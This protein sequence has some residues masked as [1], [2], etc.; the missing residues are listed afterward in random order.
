[1]IWLEPMLAV[2]GVIL[3]DQ[4][5]KALVMSRGALRAPLGKRPFLSI[6]TVLNRRGAMAPIVGVP[7]LLAIWAGC[8]AMAALTLHHGLLGSG[9]LGPLGIGAAIGGA[10]GNLLDRLRLGAV[11]DFI[12]IGPW[13]V[14]NLADAA[15]VVGAGLVLLAMR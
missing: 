5:S 2:T 7:M 11:V 12:A 6:R 1:M 14:F 3:A 10:T 9:F 15:M 4:L 13:P 8:I